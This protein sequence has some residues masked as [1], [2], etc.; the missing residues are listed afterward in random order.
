MEISAVSGNEDNA[1]L[2]FCS[3]QLCA[4]SHMESVVSCYCICKACVIVLL[5]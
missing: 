5:F 2:I 3:D 1:D 4:Y